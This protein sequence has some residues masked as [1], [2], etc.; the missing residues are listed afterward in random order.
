MR[1]QSQPGNR[2]LPF[3]LSLLRS[4]LGSA[5]TSL[6]WRSTRKARKSCRSH[7]A[8]STR[9]FHGTLDV[10]A[11]T[12]ATFGGYSAISDSSLIT[13]TIDIAKLS[14][15][16]FNG[17]NASSGDFEGLTAQASSPYYVYRSSDLR[18]EC[19]RKNLLALNYRNIPI[20]P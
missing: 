11:G 9:A 17:A 16:P 3:F 2:R 18:G 15:A 8:A 5:S 20:S 1:G 19:Y 10:V 13:E 12:I 6:A 4:P 14:A 7:L